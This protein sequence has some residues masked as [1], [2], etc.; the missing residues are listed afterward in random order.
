MAENVAEN[1]RSATLEKAESLEA[2]F[3]MLSTGGCSNPFPKRHWW[4][5][6]KQIVPLPRMTKPREQ[7]PQGSRSVTSKDDSK[8]KHIHVP[9]LGGACVDCRVLPGSLREKALS[10]ELG[11]KELFFLSELSGFALLQESRKAR[12]FKAYSRD[13]LY[14]VLTKSYR[15]VLDTL[16]EASLIEVALN[17]E[18]KE[19]YS[20]RHHT[21]KQYR[22]NPVLTKELLEGKLFY[23]ELKDKKRELYVP[24]A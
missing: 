17:S 9:P 18:G 6:P 22:L 16:L 19:S 7:T 11:D 15:R 2:P 10:R 23:H 12:Y 20:T 24:F 14:A 5:A 3:H 8:R 1:G 4:C 13:W 21:S